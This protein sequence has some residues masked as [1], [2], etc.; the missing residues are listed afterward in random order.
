MAHQAVKLLM[1]IPP[2]QPSYPFQFRFRCCLRLCCSHNVSPPR[3]VLPRAL[4]STSVT[5]FHRYYGPSDFLTIISAPSLLHLSAN[6]PFGRGEWSGSP[7]FTCLLWFHAVLS[8][9]G[10][11]P[12][13]SPLAIY[14]IVLSRTLT[15]S[16]TSESVLTGLNHFSLWLTAYNLP[17]YA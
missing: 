3:F 14:G 6:T 8:D 16:A 2:R 17:V 1:L 7:T 5:S 10:G 9:P 11:V 12:H 13:L 15:P 4:P